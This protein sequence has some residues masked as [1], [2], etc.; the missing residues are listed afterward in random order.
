M[1]TSKI[2]SVIRSVAILLLF[3]L[4]SNK[5]FSSTGFVETP[6]SIIDSLQNELN[7]QGQDTNRVKTL[8]LFGVR[9]NSKPEEN[10]VYCKEALELAIKLNFKKGIADAKKASAM[11]ENSLGH[12]DVGIQLLEEAI[13]I[14]TELSDEVGL[15][16]AYSTIG[17][18]LNNVGDRK[19]AIDY[20]M[21]SLTIREK[22]NNK[23]EIAASLNNIGN[24]YQDEGKYDEAQHIS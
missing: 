3:V 9:L 11:A 18:Q 13:Q 15:A 23:N 19:K 16:Q 22:L 1:I 4:A 17:M 2:Y 8:I 21:M 10:L 12:I 6:N 20:L 7:R 24:L 5:S 14:F